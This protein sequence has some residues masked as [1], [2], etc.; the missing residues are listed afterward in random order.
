MPRRLFAVLLVALSSALPARAQSPLDDH[1]ANLTHLARIDYRGGTDLAFQGH[2]AFAGDWDGDDNGVRIIDIADP[3]KP[4][5]VGH[6]HCAGSQNDVSVWGNLLFVS[7]DGRRESAACSAVAGGTTEGVRIVDISNV[8]APR[9]IK[10]VQTECGSHTHTLLP[11]TARNRVLLY[12]QSS[13]PGQRTEM[14]DGPDSQCNR[15]TH[16]RQSVIEVPLA[17]PAAA[18]VVSQPSVA[19]GA[20][21]SL[22]A[23]TPSVGCHDVTLFMPRKLAGG[24]CLDETQIWDLSDPVHP[25]T[26]AHIPSSVDAPIDIHHTTGFSWD[27]SIMVLGDEAGGGNGPACTGVPDDRLGALYF[28]DV[29]NAASPV[30]KGRFSLPRPRVAACTAHN[31]NVIPMKD[32]NVLVMAWYTGGINVIDFTDPAAP[33]EIAHYWHFGDPT[34]ELPGQQ[35]ASDTWSAYWYNGFIYVNGLDGFN[36]YKLDD[37]FATEPASFD[38]LNPQTQIAWVE[39]PSRPTARPTP[40]VL[41]GG[42]RRPLASTG[43]AGV[44]WALATMVLGGAATLA[45]LVRRR[46]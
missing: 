29:S 12:V 20:Q 21:A 13:A 34:E 25:R 5:V 17:S 36:A 45:G 35:A 33:R 38:V 37:D 6:F 18:R 14:V 15:A 43:V 46:V 41:G 42:Q 4:K 19:Y 44:P 16:A 9:V 10:F 1:S 23:G 40:T 27:G 28:Y 39:A 24:A 32:R 8:A 11:D 30:L 2:Y 26:L 31:F 3:A 22:Q 7:V